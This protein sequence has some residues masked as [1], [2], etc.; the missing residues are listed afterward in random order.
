MTLQGTQTYVVGR[1]RLAVIDPGPALPAHLDA[2]IDTIGDGVVASI[3]LTHNHADH[4]QAAPE[5]AARLRAPVLTGDLGLHDNLRIETDTGD[6]IAL[7]TP[8]HTPDHYSFWWPQEEAVF[9]GDLMMGGLDTALV[10]P[11]E[12]DLALYLTS[13]ERLATLPLRMIYP[14]HGP[15]IDNPGPA[16]DRYRRHRLQREEQVLAGLADRPMTEAQLTAHV[17]GPHLND[18][19]LPY[20]RAAIDAYL[21]HL[22]Q[23]GHVRRGRMGWERDT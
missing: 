20:A 7:H 5:L 16:I 13:L 18:E 10:A 3:L 4:A 23:R 15:A 17:Y 9:C 21:E 11:P 2:V 22:K 6:L 1:E 8:G 12:G 14:A 19:L